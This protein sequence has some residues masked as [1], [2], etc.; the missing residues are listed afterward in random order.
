MDKINKSQ[1]AEGV[2]T[3]LF[4]LRGLIKE[5]RATFKSTHTM[6]N[7]LPPECF[8]FHCKLS[9]DLSGRSVYVIH[10]R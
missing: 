10:A 4:H 3:S 5:K 1:Q 7:S 6:S 2:F 8:H 9:W